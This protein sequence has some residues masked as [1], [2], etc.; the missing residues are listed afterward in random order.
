MDGKNKIIL[1]RNNWYWGSSTDIVRGD[2]KAFVCVKFDK[3][4][5]PKTGYICD[6]SVFVTERNKGYGKEM[7]SYA[8]GECKK[9]GML[10]ARLH[11]DKNNVWLREWYE[12][13]GFKILS[14]DEREYEMI[15]AL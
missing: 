6:L 8:I 2:G 1:H 4:S 9:S 15:K 10:F 7:M 13:L 14:Q 11:V 5:F 12:R 3:D